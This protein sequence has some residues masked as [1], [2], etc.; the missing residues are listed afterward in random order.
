MVLKIILS[1]LPFI[2]LVRYFYL[3]DRKNK[4]P[5]SMIIFSFVFGIFLVFP[6]IIIESMFSE[7]FEVFQIKQIYRAGLNGGIVEESLK[8]LT[9]LFFIY[10]NKNFDEPFDA[11]FYSVLISLGFAFLENIFYVISY[12][13]VVAVTRPFTAIP[14]HT[15]FGTVMGYFFMKAKFFHGKEIIY[16]LYILLALIIPIFL[17]FIYN[18]IVSLNLIFGE[19]VFVFLIIYL[20]VLIEIAKKSID[21]SDNTF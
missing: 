3:R 14:A 16:R 7:V 13:M 20:G 6:A 21:E 17:H 5:L 12:G 4:E 8:F 1:V 18:F 15:L 2:V 19:I 9:F 10:R 11:I